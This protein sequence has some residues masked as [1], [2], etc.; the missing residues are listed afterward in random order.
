MWGVEVGSVPLAPTSVSSSTETDE[1]IGS[2]IFDS[3][4]STTCD[5][6]TLLDI[7]G[8]SLKL[9]VIDPGYDLLECESSW[10]LPDW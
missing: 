10:T 5:A 6:F 9:L 3:K 1:G 2:V 8:R 7:L 4:S